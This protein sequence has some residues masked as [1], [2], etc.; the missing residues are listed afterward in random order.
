VTSLG[1]AIFAFLAA[2]V[3]K[4]IDAAQAKLCP[5]YRSIAPDTRESAASDRLFGI[6]RKL[7]FAFGDPSSA[8]LALGEML[9]SLK[10]G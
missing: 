9:P 1:S 3:F 6:Y 4:S 2:G 5:S 8:P 7:Y 10:L